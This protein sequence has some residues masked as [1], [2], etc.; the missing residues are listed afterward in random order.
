M[1]PRHPYGESLCQRKSFFSLWFL[2]F[3]AANWF[4]QAQALS[5]FNALRT[6]FTDASSMLVSTPAPHGVRPLL[7]L[8]WI[9][10]IAAASSPPPLQRG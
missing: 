10:A 8:I 4:F 1:S 9:Y 7:C 5:R 3:F 6:A 2:C